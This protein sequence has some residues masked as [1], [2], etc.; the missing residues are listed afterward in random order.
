[1]TNYD[2]VKKVNLWFLASNISNI[3]NIGSNIGVEYP[4]GPILRYTVTV[5]G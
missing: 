2:T 4:E 3:S 1:M 5:V